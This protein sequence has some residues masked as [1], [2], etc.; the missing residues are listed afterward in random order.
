MGTLLT[1][2][3]RLWVM[4]LIVGVCNAHKSSSFQSYKTQS[5][6]KFV[7]R[8]GSLELYNYVPILLH[9]SMYFLLCIPNTGHFI[10]F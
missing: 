5:V 6:E 1:W 8:N 2:R 4:L 9:R 3:S 10:A 7:P